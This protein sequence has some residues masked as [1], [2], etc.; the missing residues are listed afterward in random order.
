M[1][2]VLTLIMLPMIASIGFFFGVI[3]MDGTLAADT[4]GA[5][6]IAL[7]IGVLVGAFR[8]TSAAEHG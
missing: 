4:A 1:A 6:F 2:A 8:I 5:M 3:R 7:A